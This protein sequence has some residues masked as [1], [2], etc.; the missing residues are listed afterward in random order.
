MYLL[1]IITYY[2]RKN[3]TLLLKLIRMEEIGCKTDTG[4]T[5]FVS[6]RY[7]VS[8]KVTSVPFSAKLSLN[9]CNSDDTM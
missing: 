9:I 5:A 2:Q 6:F 1:D 3:L 7:H 4:G 8:S